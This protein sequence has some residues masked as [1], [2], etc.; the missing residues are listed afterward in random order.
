MNA[1][2]Q[3]EQK[4]EQVDELKLRNAAR[5]S[6]ISCPSAEELPRDALW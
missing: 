6:C 1:Q 2:I 4:S 3:K 5:T